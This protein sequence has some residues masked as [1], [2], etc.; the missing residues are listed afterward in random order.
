M[1]IK[2]V[3]I[4]IDLENAAFGADG[5]IEVARILRTVAATYESGTLDCTRWPLKDINGNVVGEATTHKIR[6]R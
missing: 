2:R 5:G 1:M 6:R 4:E 3:N